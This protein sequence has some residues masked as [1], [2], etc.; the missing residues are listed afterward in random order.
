[1]QFG[2]V[3]GR[4]VNLTRVIGLLAAFA[5]T[6]FVAGSVPQPIVRTV[7]VTVTDANG[8]AV[9]GLTAADFTITEGGTE[10]PM[11][12]AAPA[13]ARM[14]LTVMA[15]ERLANASVRTGIF[16]FARRLQ[17]FAETALIAIGHRT[18]SLVD[19]T[20]DVDAIAAGLRRFSLIPQAQSN[21]TE[22]VLDISQ[23]VERQ[24]P[25][26][27]VIVVV[28]KANNWDGGA[29]AKDV[30]DHVRQSGALLYAV[31]IVDSPSTGEPFPTVGESGD[32]LVAEPTHREEVL[33][34]GTKQSGG[35][36]MEVTATAG[37]PKALQQIAADL[38]A[39]YVI[40][41]TLP[42]GVKRDR[43]VTVSLNRAGVSL[44]APSLLP[45][46]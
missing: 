13:T 8:A 3:S 38:S 26:R 15:E 21:F 4:L 39:Q 10:R 30:L 29:S 9:P 46:R 34:G 28:V 37:V 31:A 24:R 14:H 27:P 16:E 23:K 12:K 6:P 45:D 42:D 20:T 25:E 36:L 35:R 41:Y 17:P 40:Q 32:R 22:A 11:Q 33:E 5:T 7:Y 2:C 19:Y 44:R 43:R 18:V 1:M